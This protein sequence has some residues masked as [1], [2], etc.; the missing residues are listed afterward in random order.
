MD[1]LKTAFLSKKTLGWLV[2]IL[3]IMGKRNADID[4][5]VEAVQYMEGIS[6]GELPFEFEHELQY[7]IDKHELGKITHVPDAITSRFLFEC[8]KAL[9]K[10]FID[11]L[12]KVGAEKIR[13]EGKEYYGIRGYPPGEKKSSKAT[14]RALRASRLTPELRKR[15][16]PDEI[17]ELS[18]ALSKKPES[19]PKIKC[20]K[21]SE[22]NN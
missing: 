13:A 6:K 15:M 14:E 4:K 1:Y 12:G 22:K 17:K 8:L 19:I 5:A 10:V 18:E 11:Y 21:K 7:L 20:L 2:Y 9:R 3:E 16:S